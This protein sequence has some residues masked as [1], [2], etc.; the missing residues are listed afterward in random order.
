MSILYLDVLYVVILDIV[1]DLGYCNIMVWRKC[2]LFLVLKA[3]L[4]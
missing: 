1:L 3:A 4:K 2:C